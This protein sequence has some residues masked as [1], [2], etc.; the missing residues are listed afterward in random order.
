MISEGDGLIYCP[1]SQLGQKSVCEILNLLHVSKTACLKGRMYS[2]KIAQ[3]T[4][5]MQ[6]FH[7]L[8]IHSVILQYLLYMRWIR[9]QESN[10][11]FAWHFLMSMC[12][13]HVFYPLWQKWC[14]YLQNFMKCVS[15]GWM[16]CCHIPFWH[17]TVAWLKPKVSRHFCKKTVIWANQ[18]LPGLTH[19]LGKSL[20]MEFSMYRALKLPIT[21]LYRSFALTFTS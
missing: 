14:H 5:L 7:A 21:V 16:T 13:Q 18:R 2:E 17:L 19:I 20:L 9:Q 11:F 8:K 4:L 10:H 1:C 12:Q 3:G 6:G 15:K